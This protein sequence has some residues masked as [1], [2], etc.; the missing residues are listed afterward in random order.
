MIL[1]NGAAVRI[2]DYEE[3]AG[4]QVMAFSSRQDYGSKGSDAFY[5]MTSSHTHQFCNCLDGIL[6][7]SSHGNSCI[8][9]LASSLPS[10]P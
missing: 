4:S 9:T 6:T 3:E 1:G 5:M 2:H 8:G 7:P 10:K